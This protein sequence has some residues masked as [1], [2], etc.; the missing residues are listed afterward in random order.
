MSTWILPLPHA[1][2]G[3]RVAIKDLIDLDGTPTTGGSRVL[4]AAH[5]PASADAACLGGLRAAGAAFVG[6]SNLH[7]L[8]CGSTGVNPHFGTP[9][10]PF[11]PALIP[12]GSSS[13]N[14]FG[15]WPVARTTIKLVVGWGPRPGL[16]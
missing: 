4:K 3:I 15:T 11:D 8:A 2:S 1:S 7:E 6:K 9:T 13:G 16:H 14:A 10:N 12:G 5:E